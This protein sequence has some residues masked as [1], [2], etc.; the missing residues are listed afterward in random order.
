MTSRITKSPCITNVIP[1]FLAVSASQGKSGLWDPAPG[2]GAQVPVARMSARPLYV[3]KTIKLPAP[4][5]ESAS[6]CRKC[7]AR[8][9]TCRAVE[10][11]DRDVGHLAVTTRCRSTRLPT[12]AR[13]AAGKPG[14]RS[15]VCY[16]SRVTDLLHI[17]CNKT[18]DR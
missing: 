18:R 11:P 1:T 7:R 15:A 17:S 8:G 3:S 14:L 2:P 4:N 9:R 12:L 6:R 16:T 13:N 10:T 5:I